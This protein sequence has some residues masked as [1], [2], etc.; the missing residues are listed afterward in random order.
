[1]QWHWCTLRYLWNT[2]RCSSGDGC[3]SSSTTTTSRLNLRSSWCV[4]QLRGKSKIISV[5]ISSKYSNRKSK[6]TMMQSMMMSNDGAGF[7]LGSTVTHLEGDEEKRRVSCY[8]VCMLSVVQYP[9]EHVRVRPRWRATS[10]GVGC[11]TLL[12]G[13]GA[14]QNLDLQSISRSSQFVCCNK[15]CSRICI[16]LIGVSVSM[17]NLFDQLGTIAE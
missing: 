3:S 4:S 17:H 2:L 9:Q 12:A 15:D 8:Y 16:E 6:T 11:R 5:N 10:V 1:M 14:G 7:F 13:G